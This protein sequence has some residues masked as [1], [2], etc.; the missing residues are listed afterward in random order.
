MILYTMLVICIVNMIIRCIHPWIKCGTHSAINDPGAGRGPCLRTY[1]APKNRG[2]HRHLQNLLQTNEHGE[3]WTDESSLEIHWWGRQVTCSPAKISAVC[4]DLGRK[5]E[6]NTHVQVI[7]CGSKESKYQWSDLVRSCH[8]RL[9][10]VI[11]FEKKQSKKKI[12]D[13]CLS[14]LSTSQTSIRSLCSELNLPDI[15]TVLCIQFQPLALTKNHQTKQH[16]NPESMKR[17]QNKI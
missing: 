6:L 2:W 8:V 12:H 10:G 4:Q 11:M 1:S 16:N 9:L 15:T 14:A 5:I 3:V 17:H 7:W 13:W